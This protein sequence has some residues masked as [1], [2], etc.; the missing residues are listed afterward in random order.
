VR[1]GAG[2]LILAAALAVLFFA[3][4]AASAGAVIAG[5]F[6]VD[7]RT[8]SVANEKALTY[9]GGPVVSSSDTYA[10]YWDPVGGYRSEWMTLIDGYLHDVG[11]ASGQLSNIFSLNGQYTGPAGTRASYASTFRGAYTDTNP[12]PSSGGC[13]EPAGQPTCLTD[14]EIRTELK[15]FI[16]ANHLP[17]GI[18]VIYFL[19]TPPA[20]TVCTDTG[21]KGNCSD[22]STETQ[23][24]EEDSTG[25]VVNANGFC[26]YHS[27]IE[28]G[29]PSPIVYAVQ[30]WIAGHAG[31]VISQVPVKT[32]V[33]TAA[34]LACQNGQQ[35]VE[36]NQQS[37]LSHFDSYETGLAD[38]IINNLS[39][40]QDDIVVDPLLNGWYQGETAAEQSDLCQGVFNPAP[41]EEL[42][43]PPETT[44]ALNISNETINGDHYY[45]QWGLSSVGITSGKGVVCWEGTE[46]IPHFTATN[47]VNGGDVVAFDAN[48]SYISLDANIAELAPDEPYQAP[49]YTWNFGDGTPEV[50]GPLDASVFHSYEYGG[51]YPVTLTVTDSGGNSANITK[52]IPVSGPPRPSSGSPSP[53]VLPAVTTPAAPVASVPQGSVSSSAPVITDFVESTSLKKATSRG[54]AVHYTVNEQVAGSVQ[55]MLE[56]SV[57]KRLGIKG[58]L[59]T[60]LAK[61]TPSETII[62]TAVLVTT[63]A[64]TGTVHV[65]FAS[66]TAARLARSHKLKLMLRLVARNASRVHPLT[67]TT[68][69]TVVLSG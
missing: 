56:T 9:H 24:E 44:H 34:T 66:K 41:A 3:L 48:E 57:A 36:P 16:A 51:D 22:S 12:Y 30:P 60:G 2:S 63:K 68:L 33:P 10:I 55:V 4:T 52:S 43:K 20:V 65:R 64:G 46:L 59:A 28:P 37:T 29:S 23:E 17:T 47:P 49:I 26:G 45:L 25:N 15:R 14:S 19:L 27:A 62:G 38:L 67:T 8:R 7:L 39:I 40:E 42:P 53:A 13:H 18:N 35:L 54:L 50:S 32:S 21:G 69:S 58:Q 1:P 61:G 5:E 31:H 11:A 6:G